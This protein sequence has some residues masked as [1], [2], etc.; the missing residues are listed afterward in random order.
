M[1]RRHDEAIHR[2]MD[3]FEMPDRF[4]E[5]LVLVFRQNKGSLSKKLRDD[6]VAL[7]EGIVS[8]AFDGFETVPASP[9][10]APSGFSLPHRTGHVEVG[11]ASGSTTPPP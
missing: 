6:E 4:A 10:R 11:F 2:T 7:I 5:N 1:L 9:A 3:A 8:E